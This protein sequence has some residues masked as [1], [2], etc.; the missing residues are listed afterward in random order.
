MKP[1]FE[2]DVYL[3]R[4]TAKTWRGVIT[5]AGSD[6]VRLGNVGA[7]YVTKVLEREASLPT[8]LDLGGGL[9]VAI[10]HVS[11]VPVDRPA[12]YVAILERPVMFGLMQAPSDLTPVR[13]VFLIAVGAAAAHLGVLQRVVTAIQDREF[14]LS[15][16]ASDGADPGVVR[17]LADRL[18][19]AQVT[20]LH[21]VGGH[22]APT[23][24][25]ESA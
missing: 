18:G 12:V 24:E 10:P 1:A 22:T 25:S 21:R 13:L 17:D 11:G 4:M 16:A 5:V 9:G 14:V 15:L 19:A 2:G 23:T 7:D 6:L 3:R 20:P 8:G